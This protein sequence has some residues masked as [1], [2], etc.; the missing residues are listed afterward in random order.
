MTM[1]T[2]AEKPFMIK[3]NFHDKNEWQ[4][5]Q[6]N[7]GYLQKKSAAYFIVDAESFPDTRNKTGPPP[8]LHLH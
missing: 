4:S 3:M 2:D 1:S 5:P 6:T 7:N 8:H